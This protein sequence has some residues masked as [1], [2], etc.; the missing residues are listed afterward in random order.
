MNEMVVNGCFAWESMT[1]FHLFFRLV[2]QK[3]LNLI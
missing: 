2:K 1:T 3:P